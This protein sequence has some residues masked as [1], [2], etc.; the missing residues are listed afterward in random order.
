MELE[1]KDYLVEDVVEGLT[2]SLEGTTLV[3]NVEELERIIK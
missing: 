2:P 3:V 1:I